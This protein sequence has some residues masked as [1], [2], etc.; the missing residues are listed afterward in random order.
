MSPPTDG[1][2]PDAGVA[3]AQQYLR[4]ERP[5]SALVAIVVA[6]LF[7]GTYLLTSLVPAVAVAAVLAVVVRAPVL[8]PHGTVR[9]RSDD[10]L[11]TVRTA[12][13]GPTP[14]VLVF[15]WGVADDVTT[16]DDT[17]T[18]STSYLFGLR[19]ADVTVRTHTETTTHDGTRVVMEVTASNQP[20]ATYTASIRADGDQTRIDV[21]YDSDRRFGLRR[22]PQQLFAHRYRDE[23]LE[24]QGYTVIERESH[25]R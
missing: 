6:S 11:E 5:L 15:Q 10:D 1:N 20:W 23:A 18:Y 24:A 8:R 22:L 17:A 2:R 19:S 25:L 7:I 12:F 4:R 13:A 21:E 16:D 9:L 14:P 3:V